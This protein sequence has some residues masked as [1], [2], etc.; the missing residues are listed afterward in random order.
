MAVTIELDFDSL[1]QLARQADGMAQ[2][3]Q[4]L[5]PV[6]KPRAES[7][8]TVINDAFSDSQSPN[9]EAWP[10]LKPATVAKRRKGSRRPLVDTGL[11]RGSV[12]TEAGKGR[13]VF[14]VGGT[15][16]G[17]A[18][19]HQFGTK[20]IPRRAFLPTD[21]EGNAEFRRGPARRWLDRTMQRVL[22]FILTGEL[23]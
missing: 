17:Y 1:E 13:V 18:P 2:R 9:D 15:A 20:H 19:F 8:R 16:A 6:L 3:A 5:T 22:R 12:R 21:A 14:G 4:D 7:L 10:S 11:L 23:R